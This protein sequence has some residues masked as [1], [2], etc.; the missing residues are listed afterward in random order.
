M[1]QYQYILTGS[2]V[3]LARARTSYVLKRCYDAQKQLKMIAGIEIQHQ[4]G[5]RPL[6]SG[7]LSLDVT[8]YLPLARSMSL[9][10][11]KQLLGTYHTIR[12]DTSNLLKFI[13]DVCQ[14]IVYKEDCIISVITA[15]KL[16]SNDP[17]TIFTIEEL[18]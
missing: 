14:N 11:N 4:H 9:K 13:E 2:P 17:K 6:L 16:Y 7:P 15:K 10:R 12:P 8:F 1:M 3:P 5:N 18:K